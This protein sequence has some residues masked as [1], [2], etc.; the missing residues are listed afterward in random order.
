[1]IGLCNK[2]TFRK[3]NFLQVRGEKMEPYKNLEG[4]SGVK[5]YEIGHH[6]ITLEFQDGDVYL[7][8]YQSA[9]REV[10]EEMI[11]LAKEGKGLNGY[12]SRRVRAAYAEKLV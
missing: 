3:G 2:Q 7:Y 8:N 10:I 11:R 1:M 6:S 4:A 12:V 9:G 5:A